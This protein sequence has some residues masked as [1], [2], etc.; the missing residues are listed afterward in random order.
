[1]AGLEGRLCGFARPELRVSLTAPGDAV[2][3]GL[4][5]DRPAARPRPARGGRVMGD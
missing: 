2:Q 4:T 1:M 3:R 5:D